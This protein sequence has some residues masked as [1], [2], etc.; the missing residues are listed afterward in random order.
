[1]AIIVES[2]AGDNP[3]ANSY[4]TVVELDAFA[5]LR[6]VTL[7]T[8]EADK[9][10]LLINGTDY[11]ETF[12]N[13]FQGSTVTQDQPL[14]F[15]RNNVSVNGFP[16]ASDSI[17]QTLKNG[18]MQAAIESITTSLTPNTG[19]NIKKEKVDVIEVTYQDGTGSLY[20][21]TFPSIDK[22]IKPLLS[23]GGNIY[24]TSPFR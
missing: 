20:A 10:V 15:P 16:V 4:V 12:F 13:R 8:L 3:A 24:I 11:T 22:Y 6:G 19:Q 5:D 14:Q 17:P 9:E 18:Q 21:P 23:N 2:G 1:M 7:P